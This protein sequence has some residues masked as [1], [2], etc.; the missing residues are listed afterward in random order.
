MEI[1]PLDDSLEPLN[2]L[3]KFCIALCC[4]AFIWPTVWWNK[5]MASDAARRTI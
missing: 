4:R 1:L 2:A 3:P 5:E